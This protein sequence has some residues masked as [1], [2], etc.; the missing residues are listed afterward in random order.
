MSIAVLN[1]FSYIF[2]RNSAQTLW[3]DF[4]SAIWIPL[5][6]DEP[7]PNKTSRPHLEGGC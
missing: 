2:A 7:D 6:V 1:L 4:K 3:I 5:P